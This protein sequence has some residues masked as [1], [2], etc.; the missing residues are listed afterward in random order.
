MS[1][2]KQIQDKSKYIFLLMDN[3][4]LVGSVACYGNEVDDL[5][6]DKKYQG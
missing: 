6:V 4:R 3:D 2:Y 5:F 1:D